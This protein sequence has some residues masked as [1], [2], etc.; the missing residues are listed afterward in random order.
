MSTLWDLSL[1]LLGFTLIIVLHEL[2]H[3]LAAKWAGVRVL[4][5]AV[6]FGPAIVSFRK[7]LGW[8]RG[9]S[10]ARLRAMRREGDLPKAISPTEYRI[11][12]LPFGGYVKMLGQDDAD[13]TATSQEADSYQRCKP[14]KKLVI[15]S[16]GVVM[17]VLAALVLFIIVMMA[18]RSVEP[19]V[20]G[21]VEEGSPAHVAGLRAGDRVLSINEHSAST[22]EDIVLESAMAKRNTDLRMLVQSE[23][24]SEPRTLLVRPEVNQLIG[25]LDI[26]VMPARSTQLFSLP[27][28]A[29]PEEQAQLRAAYDRAGL[30]DVAIASSLS[31]VE[32]TPATSLAHAQRLAA[33]YATSNPSAKDIAISLVQP[34]GVTREVRVPLH[35]SMQRAL[36]PWQNERVLEHRHVAGLAGVL[37]VAEAAPDSRAHSLG[38]RTGDIFARLGDAEFPSESEGLKQI[39]GHAGRAIAVTVLRMTDESGAQSAAGTLVRLEGVSVTSEGTIGFSAGQSFDVAPIL[40]AVP[41]ALQSASGEPLTLPTHNL[42]IVPGMRVTSVQGEPV[43]TLAEAAA[44]LRTLL[45]T[46]TGNATTHAP[47][48]TT[49]TLEVQ[50]FSGS[51]GTWERAQTPLTLTLTSEQ[52]TL[53]AGLAPTI[54]VSEGLFAP[55]MFTLQAKSPWQAVVLGFQ[56][57]HRKMLKTYLTFA[58][59][60]QGTVKV[61][62][63]KGPVG[64][65]HM[66]TLLAGRGFMW[67]LFFLAIVNINL[68]VIN[69]LPLPI[70]DGGQALMIIYEW[71]RGKP[72]PVQF[73]NAV[74]LAGMLLIGSVFLFVTFNDIRNLLGM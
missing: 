33:A 8:C 40:S 38:L 30:T 3:F 55:L 51:E 57:T 63:L 24:A 52:A 58:R 1:V 26:G 11:N 32:G 46:G 20:I 42:G 31:H 25:L 7:G 17:N 72:V 65:A 14:A 49:I 6:G 39:R 71:V 9:S 68:A 69:F 22:F 23:D 41:A 61:E 19:P 70:V 27:S 35:S 5:F 47:S 74:M 34:D 28:G 56:E 29:K 10:E 54:G 66:G 44:R 48:S 12:W 45:A 16:A 50:R 4:A 15:I 73:Q 64:I 59:I 2:G 18:G 36:A 53:V 62:H 37:R 60:V 67:L 13:P 21:T 43:A